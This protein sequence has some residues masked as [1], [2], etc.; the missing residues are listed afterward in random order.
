VEGEEKSEEDSG[1]SHNKTLGNK[2]TIRKYWGTCKRGREKFIVGNDWETSL[3]GRGRPSK[4][5]RV[6][7]KRPAKEKLARR[8]MRPLKGEFG[9]PEIFFG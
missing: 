2:R 3:E 6:L 8:D 4:E 7:I 1:M 5:G 9:I